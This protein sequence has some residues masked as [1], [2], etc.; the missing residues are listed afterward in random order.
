[1]AVLGQLADPTSGVWEACGYQPFPLGA[2]TARRQP[3]RP[4]TIALAG[5]RRRY[6]V[7]IAGD[8]EVPFDLAGTSAV[9]ACASTAVA[10]TA[11]RA[12]PTPARSAAST[13]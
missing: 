3:V 1:M 11:C 13:T 2:P 4:D 12:T 7:V 8:A 10:E 6:D 9:R 5:A